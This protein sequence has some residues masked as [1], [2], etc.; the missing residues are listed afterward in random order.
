MVTQ[1]HLALVMA[2][3]VRLLILDEPTLGLDILYRKEFYST[4][5]SDYFDENRTIVVTTHQVEEVENILTDLM[6]I[7]HGRLVL[8][9]SMEDVAERYTEVLVR[10][11]D[12]ERARELKPLHERDVFGKRLFLFEGVD[13]ER[14]QAFGELHTPNVADLFVAKMKGAAA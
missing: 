5:L 3:D 14:L 13:R 12:A 6:F 8:N 11:E 7:N 2:I 10:P 9:E 4:L 1:L